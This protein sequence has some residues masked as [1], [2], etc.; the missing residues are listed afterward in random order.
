MY[1]FNQ[2]GQRTRCI[3]HHTFHSTSARVR[4][5]GDK[6]RRGKRGRRGEG[7]R[8]GG[9]GYLR[10]GP[11]FDVDDTYLEQPGVEEAKGYFF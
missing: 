2:Q 6:G 9:G 7:G 4:E 5:G 1:V 10:L 3:F 11:A 8:R